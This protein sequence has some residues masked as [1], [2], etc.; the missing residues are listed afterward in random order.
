MKHLRPIQRRL[1]NLLKRVKVKVASKGESQNSPLGTIKKERWINGICTGCGYTP[2]PWYTKDF[3][4]EI[5]QYE[6]WK[7]WNYC[8][9]CGAP[10]IKYNGR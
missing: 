8:P 9:N 3:F 2:I 10:M 6:F 5:E 4:R 1:K 7:Q